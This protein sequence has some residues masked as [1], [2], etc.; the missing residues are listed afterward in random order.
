MED[1]LSVEGIGKTHPEAILKT[2]E[3]EKLI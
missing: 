2:L 3:E 1:L